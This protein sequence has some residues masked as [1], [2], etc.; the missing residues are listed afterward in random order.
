MNKYFSRKDHSSLTCLS[1]R[2]GQ[3][4]SG[5]KRCDTISTIKAIICSPKILMSHWYHGM[6]T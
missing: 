1:S 4:D 2:E 5:T 3:G 6:L